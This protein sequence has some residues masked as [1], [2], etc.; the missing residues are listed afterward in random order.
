MLESVN[1]TFEG[2]DADEHLVGARQ[3]GHSLVGLD[4]VVNAGMILL[5]T[6]QA[7]KRRQRIE[8]FIAAKSPV[9]GSVDLPTELQHVAWALPLVNEFVAS[10]GADYVKAFLGWV[11]AMH[12]GRKAEGVE[13]MEKMIEML[14]EVNRSH[15]VTTERWQATLL[16]M[17]D[18]LQPAAR[19][20]V[21]PIGRT[22]S[23]LRITGG[24]GA[25]VTVDEPMADAI[26]SK[27]ELEVQDLTEMT[28]KVDGVFHHARQIKV[29]HP[30]EPGRYI[31]CDVRD[32][33]FDSV[34]NPYTE[35]LQKLARIVV[36][37]RPVLKNGELHKLYVMDFRGLSE[38]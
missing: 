2:R 28:V 14:R 29:E 15:E 1:I 24:V 25:P 21:E 33:T 22:A 32:P 5:A 16:S 11:L 4:T 27:E 12:G 7:P 35:A 20:M 13:Q 23:T 19:Q 30:T 38:S 31:T 8:L 17:V 36:L 6:G 10:K 37:A 3:L 34:P 26:R 18:K 9:S